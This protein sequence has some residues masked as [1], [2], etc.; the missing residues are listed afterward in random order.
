MP[1][2]SR[3]RK[4]FCIKF[5]LTLS[6]MKNQISETEGF[7]FSSVPS[8]THDHDVCGG[9]YQVQYRGAY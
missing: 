6:L 2:A 7:L 4:T 9:L 5:L 8:L 3:A 1:A